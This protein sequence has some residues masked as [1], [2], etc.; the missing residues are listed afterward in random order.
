MHFIPKEKFVIRKG[1]AIAKS[2]SNKWQEELL[3]KGADLEL[4]RNII[5]WKPDTAYLFLGAYAVREGRE[6]PSPAA[7]LADAGV[8]PPS[9]ALLL[10]PHPSSEITLLISTDTNSLMVIFCVV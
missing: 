7:M 1:E 10:L 4:N 3:G 2:A 5:V 6:A 9:T 8:I